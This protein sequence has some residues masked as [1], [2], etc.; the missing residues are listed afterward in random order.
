MVDGG[1]LELDEHH[2]IAQP[3]RQVQRRRTGQEIV[4]LEQ[5]KDDLECRL[6][7]TAKILNVVKCTGTV[8]TVCSSVYILIGLSLNTGIV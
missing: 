7:K 6:C 1:E 5:E 3:H 2:V 8:S 4:H